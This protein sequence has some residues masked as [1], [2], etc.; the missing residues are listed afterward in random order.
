MASPDYLSY[1]YGIIVLLGGIS[2]YVRAGSVASLISGLLFGGVAIYG[3]TV[4]SK[5][6]RNC[7]V[8][9]A[10]ASV[11]LAVMAFRFYRTQKLMPAGL[12]MFLRVKTIAVIA[13]VL[14]YN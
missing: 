12:I 9:L 3:A 13:E 10:T 8:C 5:N 6:P 11:L 7:A 14:R 4:T 2:G 1:T